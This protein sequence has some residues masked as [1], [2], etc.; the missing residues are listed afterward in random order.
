MKTI[1]LYL[2]NAD[3]E[4][5]VAFLSIYPSI[6][7]LERNQS[8][9][10]LK[11]DEDEINLQELREL[12][13]QELYHDFTAFIVPSSIHFPI[14][15]ILPSLEKLSSGVYQ[16]EQ[17]IPEIVFLKHQDIKASLK[18]YYTE[19]VG[20]ETIDTVLGFIKE[21]QNASQAA[22]RLFMH[23][24]TLNYRLDHFMMKTEIDIKSF[25]GALAIYLLFRV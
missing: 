11:I 19:L 25:Q 12:A 13:I 3:F 8:L 21:N 6:S 15:V 18:T 2:K 7:I 10:K 22:K 23:R 20:L 16:I 9:L 4:S 17:L 5:M 14:D 24:N 1:Y